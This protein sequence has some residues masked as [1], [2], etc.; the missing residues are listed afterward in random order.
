VLILPIIVDDFDLCTLISGGDSFFAS[1]LLLPLP[2]TVFIRLG[3]KVLWIGPEPSVGEVTSVAADAA[4]STPFRTPFESSPFRFPVT[5]LG[6][7]DDDAVTRER[8]F[9][10]DVLAAAAKC[11]SF[12]PSAG[13]CDDSNGGGSLVTAAAD[14]ATLV[15]AIEVTAVAS[16]LGAN[17]VAASDT[18]D[19]AA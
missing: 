3:G 9:K 12:R 1:V 6:V 2:L 14:A 15:R 4:V 13:E 11:L 16:P 7:C 8:G 17:G 19:A 10:V 5:V 18:V